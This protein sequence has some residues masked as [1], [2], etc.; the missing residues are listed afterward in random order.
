VVDWAAT[1]R[2]A[3]G[4]ARPQAQYSIAVHD[5]ALDWQ[6]TAAPKIQAYRHA[7]ADQSHLLTVAIADA[8][9]T[10]GLDR[11]AADKTFT[12]AVA[13]A[14]ATLKEDTAL[15]RQRLTATSAD[16]DATLA[17]TSSNRSKTFADS[18]ATG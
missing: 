9:Q 4:H 7:I 8:A 3:A 2:D 5:A 12:I 18:F 17:K 15:A 10:A 11:S 1:Q 16:I 14:E 13:R 6:R